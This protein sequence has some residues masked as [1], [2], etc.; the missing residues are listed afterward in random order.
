[1]SDAVR[2]C[3]TRGSLRPGRDLDGRA[4]VR[5]SDSS[6]TES[7]PKGESAALRSDGDGTS[8]LSGERKGP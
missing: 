5:V 8:H 2:I 4:Y 1:L 6:D 7:Q 3:V